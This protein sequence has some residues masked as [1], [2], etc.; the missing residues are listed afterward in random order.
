MILLEC[1]S[2]YLQPYNLR[3]FLAALICLVSISAC[4]VFN[5]N[6]NRIF[7][8]TAPRDLQWSGYGMASTPV[9]SGNYVVY[10][11]GYHWQ[12]QIYLY[13]VNQKT[14]KLVG[15]SEQSIENFK[16]CGDY[17]IA[18]T[19]EFIHKKRPG[20]KREV[21]I[22]CYRLKD[23]NP[24]WRHKTEVS[25]FEP[26][27]I[28]CGTNFYLWMPGLEVYAID[29]ETGALKWRI[30]KVPEYPIMAGIFMA[31]DKDIIYG[32]LPGAKLVIM[33]GLTGKAEKML[34]LASMPKVLINKVEIHQNYIALFG[35]K[36]LLTVVDF[37][38]NKVVLQDQYGTTVEGIA[39]DG[40][41]IFTGSTFTTEN[42]KTKFYLNCIDIKKKKVKWQKELEAKLLLNPLIDGSRVYIGFTEKDNQLYCLDRDTGSVIWQKDIGPITGE[43]II[44]DDVL[45]LCGKDD[46]YALEGK[47]GKTIWQEKPVQFSPANSP[48][49]GEGKIFF[50]GQD[51]N[52]YAYELVNL[53]GS[54][55]KS[56]KSKE[57]ES[58]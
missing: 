28:S 39:I 21:E 48:A 54:N 40:S 7:Q 8:Y 41:E 49:L 36:G 35:S 5:K 31:G 15:K 14:G 51:S 57:Q 19:S 16:V 23:A 52:L 53:K 29:K 43:P 47:T 34:S 27:I 10:R 44:K 22:I 24:I 30:Q 56:D 9:V 32:A 20:L 6:S 12:N 2:K 13:I 42:Q 37:D 33:D 45:Y 58:R 3:T 11:G 4:A 17:A 1:L 46:F 25:T 38:Q 18:T 55:T 26:R 50:T